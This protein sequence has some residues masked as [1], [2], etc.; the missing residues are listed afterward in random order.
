MLFGVLEYIPKFCNGVKATSDLRDVLVLFDI[1]A[2][3]RPN[4]W[5]HQCEL[6]MGDD[7]VTGD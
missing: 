7:D 1:F 6:A 2:K 3:P 5:S 4:Q